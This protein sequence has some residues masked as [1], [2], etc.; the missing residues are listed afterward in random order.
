[1]FL[2]IIQ[3]LFKPVEDPMKWIEL[4]PNGVNATKQ[5]K[6]NLI[7]ISILLGLQEKKLLFSLTASIQILKALVNKVLSLEM[8]MQLRG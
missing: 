7:V 8:A 6:F 4:I 3:L 1:M 5:T 2:P